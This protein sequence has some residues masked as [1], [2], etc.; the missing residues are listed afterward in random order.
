MELGDSSIDPILDEE[1][2]EEEGKRKWRE[3]KGGEGKGKE[4]GKEVLDA[5]GVLDDDHLL[6][7]HLLPPS[8]L[9]QSRS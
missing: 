8:R 5:V 3:R 4:D 7:F 2:E 9:L 6:A 1:R